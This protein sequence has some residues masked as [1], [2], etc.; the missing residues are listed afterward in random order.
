[1][2]A[3]HPT[4]NL[5]SKKE[6]SIALAVVMALLP[7]VMMY[8]VPVLDIGISTL[9][10]VVLALVLLVVMTG[11]IG[12]ISAWLFILA[13]LYFGY[14][15]IKSDGITIVTSLA[16]LCIYLGLIAGV[17]DSSAFRR[18]VEL[19]STLAA[20]GV[21]GQVLV[22]SVA[23]IHIPM[24]NYS[25]C[26]DSM[27]Q[28]KDAILT[29]YSQ[30]EPLYRPS[31]FFLEPSHMA[32][33]CTVGLLSTLLGKR[34]N[35]KIGVVI[36]IGLLLSTSGIGM[37]LCAV[38]WVC[39]AVLGG[40]RGVSQRSQRIL[41]VALFAVVAVVVLMQIGLFSQITARFAGSYGYSDSQYN[42]LWGRTMYWDVY[43]APMSGTDLLFGFG[44]SKMPDVYFT[45]LMETVYCYGIVGLVLLYALYVGTML[46]TKGAGKCL[47]A[48]LI[49][50]SF[51]A[52]LTGLI[53]M[54][55][56]FAAA[57]LLDDQPHEK[58]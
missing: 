42:A 5:P 27:A 19:V 33:Y 25:F 45:G 10:I 15:V 58:A 47:C 17:A 4:L 24:I 37:V 26:I 6:S 46:Y 48:I 41:V 28:Y 34:P 31:A 38:S 55:F 3:G 40:A 13:V 9:A 49:G 20:I 30:A 35:F 22:H 29:G 39:Y 52:N 1:M 50:M 14:V 44:S 12:S 32:T 7:I 23:G 56:F 8:K 11:R 21:V 36:S 54:S 43:I 57:I 53:F 2:T 18:T 16:V 51:V